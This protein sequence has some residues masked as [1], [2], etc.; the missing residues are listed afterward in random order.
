[1][2]RHFSGKMNLEDQFD[3][4]KNEENDDRKKY[5]SDLLQNELDL[6]PIISKKKKKSKVRFSL[7][8]IKN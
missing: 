7:L 1:M 5:G 6:K 4:T 3:L 2:N 8:D